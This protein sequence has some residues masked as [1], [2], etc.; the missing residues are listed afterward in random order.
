MGGFKREGTY[1]SLWLNPTQY[2]KA[3]ILQLKT[4]KKGN[5]LMENGMVHGNTGIPE[6]RRWPRNVSLS[7]AQ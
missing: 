1:V 3:I 6:L 2:C 4:L 7:F 5:G